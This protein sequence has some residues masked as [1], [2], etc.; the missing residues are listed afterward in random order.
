MSDLIVP[1]FSSSSS[2]SKAVEESRTRTRTSAARK[3][4][5]LKPP[6]SKRCRDIPAS[7]N[8][9]KRLDCGAFTAAF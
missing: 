4:A 8:R 9:A 1:S 2:S 3:K 6:Q 7:L 5:V